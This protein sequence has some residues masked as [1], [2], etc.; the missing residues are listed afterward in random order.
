MT[1][2]RFGAYAVFA[3]VTAALVMLGSVHHAYAKV[4]LITLDELK[5]ISPRGKEEYM[6]VI[7]DA[8]PE[9][10][11][12]GINTRLRMAHFL[13]QVMTE[14]GGL[15]RLDENM[16]YSAAT[17]LRV[18]SRR[19]VSVADA[20]RIARKPQ[21]VANWV[22]GARLGNRGRHTDD[23]WN[24]RGSGFIQLTGRSNFRA[25]GAQIGLPLEEKPEMARQAVDGLKAAIAYWDAVGINAAAD[26][27]DR[28]RVR[29]LVN[30][31]AAH[32]YKESKVWFNKVWTKGNF[33]AKEASGFESGFE[34]AADGS[35]EAALFDEIL[36][37]R[38]LVTQNEMSTES[39]ADGAREAALK[40]YQAELGLPETGILDEDTQD[41]LLDPIEWRHREDTEVTSVRPQEDLN[42]TVT[43]VF[44]T[45]N[46]TG[47]ETSAPQ[48][49]ASNE[50]TGQM[51]DDIN[52][53]AST[54]ETLNNAGAMYSQYEM[55][56]TDTSGLVPETF[57]PYSVIGE[58][59][60]V[61]V[62]DTTVYPARAIVQILFESAPGV[63][64]LCSGALVSKDLVLTAGHCIHSGTVN[65]RF[66]SKHK[67]IPG[68]NKAVQ[69]F[70]SCNAKKAYLLA[71]WSS[72]INGLEGRY[73]DMGAIKL[74]CDIG[75]STGW[76]G[77]RSLADNEL[78]IPTVVQ[79]Y[80]GDL[81]PP[82]RQ[83]VSEDKLRVIWDQKGFYQND[84]FG[85]TSGSAV[86]MKEDPAII[87]GVHT[88][89]LHGEEPWASN[90]AFTRL[91]PDRIARIIEWIED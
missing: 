69:P 43:F 34:M 27:S 61:A 5:K 25:R 14:T 55:G 53:P 15:K 90:N 8:E 6:Q 50:G 63:E 45:A 51:A 39:S 13:T 82:G 33:G 24:Y 74:D 22:Y 11:K 52:L 62:N 65:G 37:E 48:M 3:V 57:V 46:D 1:V 12:A 56:G 83:W 19:T 30:G 38:G 26:D 67:L 60:R 66:Y 88:N 58:D 89:G 17:L 16:N 73:Y 29:K 70:G 87:I 28:L 31:P 47:T 4:G 84:T 18:F 32:G 35:G 7:V 10:E 72:S 91:T 81:A 75:L 9:F 20:N 54:T 64:N 85:G 78:E 23:G 68:R 42:Q 71:G 86:T 21:E 59:T 76:M 40:A 79:G 80:A 44:E 2:F 36:V 49:I 41:A 77:A